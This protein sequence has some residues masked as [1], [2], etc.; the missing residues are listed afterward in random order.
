MAE[1]ARNMLLVLQALCWHMADEEE[2]AGI[3]QG[4]PLPTDQFRS[5]EGIQEAFP[6]LCPLRAEN[7]G[8]V[9]LSDAPLPE[10]SV[11][12]RRFRVLTPS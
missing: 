12:G 8:P 1:N 11:A 4:H 3:R 7:L 6:L 2:R 5:P 10:H 9:S